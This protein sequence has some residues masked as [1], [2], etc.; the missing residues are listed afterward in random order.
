MVQPVIDLAECRR[1]RYLVGAYKLKT[2]GSNSGTAYR[3][4]RYKSS[5]TIVGR[6]ATNI[7]YN[8]TT[9]TITRIVRRRHRAT[10][11]V[12]LEIKQW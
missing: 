6:D 5:S 2:H 8:I 10:T 3:R 9:D 4:R 12:N 7:G 11:Y 1:G